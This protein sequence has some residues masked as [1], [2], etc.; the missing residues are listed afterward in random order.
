MT[1]KETARNSRKA[2]QFHRSAKSGMRELP[3]L[4]PREWLA[5]VAGHRRK[6]ERDDFAGDDLVS[7]HLDTT[8]FA[9]C[10]FVGADLRQADLSSSHFSFCDFREADLTGAALDGASFWHCDFT[11]AQLAHVA[12]VTATFEHCVG[13]PAR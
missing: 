7:G 6:I 4:A 9:H 10:S 5:S 8:I 1:P 3:A 13:V 2:Q 11:G 12:L